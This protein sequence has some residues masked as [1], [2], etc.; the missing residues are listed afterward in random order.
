MPGTIPAPNSGSYVE[1]N[2]KN[3][4]SQ[5]WQINKKTHF[6]VTKEKPYI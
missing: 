4:G 2:K 6:N 1:K 3:I 5:I